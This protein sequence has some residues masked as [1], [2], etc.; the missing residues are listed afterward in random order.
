MG[1][2]PFNV[3]VYGLL[4]DDN[5]RV[6]LVDEER[7]GHRFTKFPGGG[8]EHGEGTIEAIRRE[9]MEEMN[10]EVEVLD[11]FYT[12]DVFVSSAFSPQD[13]VI[14]IY[15]RIQTVGEIQFKAADTPFDFSYENGDEKLA[16]R[17][18]AI[19]EIQEDELR[20]PIDKMVLGMLKKEYIK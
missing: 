2:F 19:A 16:F 10:Q 12:T 11:H 3:R 7:S 8:L 18:K 1:G 4:V 17:W 6:L 15:Y 5:S 13:Q 9:C 14:S 20:F